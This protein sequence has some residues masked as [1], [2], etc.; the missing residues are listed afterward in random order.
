MCA[1]KKECL[2]VKVDGQKEKFQKRLLLLNIQ[3]VF[4]EFKKVNPDVQIGFSKFCEL[5]PK[6][7]VNVNSGVMHKV[8]VCEYHQ[9]VK[10][11]LFSLSVKFDYKY[12]ICK[13]ARN[14][15]IRN[16]MLYVCENCPGKQ[17]THNYLINCFINNENKLAEDISYMQ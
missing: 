5:Q 12:F 6:Y 1:G 8:C 7:V 13:A 16:C 17:G 4:L 2:T 11:M 14:I 3:E 10:V 9:N 15:E